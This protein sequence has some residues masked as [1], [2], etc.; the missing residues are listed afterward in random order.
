MDVRYTEWRCT[1]GAK[2]F[3]LSALEKIGAW[4]IGASKSKSFKNSADLITLL[5]DVDK[6]GSPDE[7]AVFLEK[8]LDQPFGMLVLNDWFYVAN[9]NGLLRFPYKPGQ[10][11][12]SGKAEKLRPCPQ[13]RPIDIGHA[14]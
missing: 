10:S 5:C 7:R 14:I 3:E 1:C 13:E 11:Q 9:T 6:D 2:Q 4:F 8:E 12:L